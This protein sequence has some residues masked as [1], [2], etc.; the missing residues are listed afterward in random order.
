LTDALIEAL[1]GGNADEATIFEAETG[2]TNW[3][4]SNP[5]DALFESLSVALGKAEPVRLIFR[6]EDT[7]RTQL[8][9]LPIELARAKDGYLI[10]SKNLQSIVHLLP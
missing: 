5:P 7:L 2:I 1:R 6:L 4:R 3:L 8:G 10:F 9:H